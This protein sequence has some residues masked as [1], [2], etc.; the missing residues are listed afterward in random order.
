[1]FTPDRHLATLGQHGHSPQRHTAAGT[2]APTTTDTG[3]TVPQHANPTQTAY[4]HLR[5]RAQAQEF[6]LFATSLGAH[7]QGDPV[8]SQTVY[9]QRGHEHT[10]KGN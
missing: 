8:D 3:N 6:T 10:R 4:A 9:I 1:M 2:A 5:R 7:A